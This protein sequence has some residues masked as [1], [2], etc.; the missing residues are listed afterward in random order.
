MISVININNKTYHYVLKNDL[1]V[2]YHNGKTFALTMG[3]LNNVYHDGETVFNN[4]QNIYA[5]PIEV[6]VDLDMLMLNLMSIGYKCYDMEDNE[7]E[8][9]VF[10]NIHIKDILNTDHRYKHLIN[11]IDRTNSKFVY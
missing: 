11:F 7:Y 10:T 5:Y 6:E 9:I 3:I 2:R 1:W 8:Y 4:I